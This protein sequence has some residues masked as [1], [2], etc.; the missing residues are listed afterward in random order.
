MYIEKL[1]SMRAWKSDMKVSPKTH[2]F[3]TC[4]LYTSNKQLNPFQDIQQPKTNTEQ[5]VNLNT[6]LTEHKVNRCLR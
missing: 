4:S 2:S 5:L 1:T 3:P 6:S